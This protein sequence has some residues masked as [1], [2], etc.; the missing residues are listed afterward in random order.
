MKK[1]LNFFSNLQK[2]KSVPIFIVRA[3]LVIGII[4]LL[5]WFFRFLIYPQRIVKS[6]K[7]L[8]PQTWK[9]SNQLINIR[10]KVLLKRQQSQI[11]LATA[12][13]EPVDQGDEISTDTD[14]LAVIE[15]QE[16]TFVRLAPNTNVSILATNSA[17]ISLK[18]TSGSLFVNFT[19][20]PKTREEIVIETPSVLVRTSGTIFMTF[21]NPDQSVKVVVTQNNVSLTKS[22]ASAE[23]SFDQTPTVMTQN[24]Q[25]LIF[26]NAANFSI[27]DV[28]LTPSETRWLE[29][30]KFAENFHNNTISLI[31]TTDQF[32]VPSPTPTPSPSP[33]PSVPP[34]PQL[35]SM[36]SE[37]YSRSSV[38]TDRGQFTLTCYGANKNSIRV[39]TDSASES[40]CSDNCPIMSVGE[41]ATRNGAV[42]AMNGMYFCP[43]DYSW[44]SSKKNTFDTLFFNSRL[45]RYFNSDNNVYSTI[46]FLVIESG[47]N[48]RFVPR[49]LEW[50]RDTG[51]QA[52]IAGNPLMVQN[53]QFIINESSL[54]EKQRTARIGTSAFAQKGDTLYL[55]IVGGASILDSASVFTTLGADNALNLDGGGSAAL[56]VNGA[57]VYGPGR[58]IPNSIMFVRK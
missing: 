24:Q 52:G 26:A 21:V 9:L 25:A 36:P 50:G 12:S 47:G 5:W 17:N 31:S 18:Q 41:Y 20:L 57:Y 7:I 44:C 55:C 37:G 51:I 28:S 56:W 35:G 46:P 3:S 33:T 13:A 40:D 14:T 34:I 4:L 42:A 23:N 29:I 43:Q 22:T 16:G 32:F 49:S 10:G 39:V 54:D 8:S 38:K 19:R 53:G 30:N 11:A 58:S 27:T 48:P 45:K 6:G 2:S 1:L 15:F